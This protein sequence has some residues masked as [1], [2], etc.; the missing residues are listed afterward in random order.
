MNYAPNPIKLKSKLVLFK[1]H[2]QGIQ[3]CSE[4]YL[5]SECSEQS[6]DVHTGTGDHTAILES[7]EVLKYMEELGSSDHVPSD[8]IKLFEN[9]NKMNGAIMEEEK[10]M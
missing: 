4:D 5:L 3:D 8:K 7:E 1:A 10:I 6:V 9:T 2:H